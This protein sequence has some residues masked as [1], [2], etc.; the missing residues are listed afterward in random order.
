MKHLVFVDV[1]V[2]K[3]FHRVIVCAVFWKIALSSFKNINQMDYHISP[4]YNYHL[5]RMMERKYGSISDVW[6][7]HHCH[8]PKVVA[9]ASYIFLSSVLNAI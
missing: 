7:S 1:L 4:E 8:C 2:H 5:S 3:T 9:L 6:R